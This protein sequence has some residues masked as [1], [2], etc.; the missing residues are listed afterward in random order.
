MKLTEHLNAIEQF[1]LNHRP[2]SE[3]RTHL[4]V[5]Q[6]HLEMDDSLLD[7]IANK[8][9]EIAKVTADLN[10]KIAALE[11]KAKKADERPFDDAT[12]KALKHFLDRN[13][14]I[15]PVEIAGILGC[16][17]GIAQH[18]IDL[19]CAQGFVTSAMIPLYQRGIRGAPDSGYIITSEGRKYAIDHAG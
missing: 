13:Q 2:P 4:H 6:Q 19:L 18:H 11:A 17:E 5:L 3:V 12:R 1:V 9:A 7:R 16:K 15:L 10:A 8:D 14:V